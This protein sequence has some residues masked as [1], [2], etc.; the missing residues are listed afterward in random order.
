MD[1]GRTDDLNFSLGHHPW[2]TLAHRQGSS[3]FPSV[4]GVSI[5]LGF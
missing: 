2:G 1:Q 3:G 5:L 4:S